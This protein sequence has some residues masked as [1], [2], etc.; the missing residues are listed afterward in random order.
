MGSFLYAIYRQTIG[1]ERYN[2]NLDKLLVDDWECIFLR[3]DI[4]LTHS[5]ARLHCWKML[6][7]RYGTVQQQP[8]QVPPNGK[9]NFKKFSE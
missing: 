4:L 1:R 2:L 6:A 8:T 5:Y 7:N 9:Y 3:N